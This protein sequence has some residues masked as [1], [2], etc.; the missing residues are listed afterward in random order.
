LEPNLTSATAGP[1][2]S[3]CFQIGRDRE[4]LP[5]RRIDIINLDGLHSVKEILADDIGD[6]FLSK[7]LVIFAWFIQNQAQRGPRSA[8]FVVDHPDGRGFSLIFEG[9]L[10]HFSRF[11]SNVKHR[12]PPA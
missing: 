5:V 9:F 3:L 2:V 8:A 4:S 6:T 7:N 11:L 1:A 10:D 12:F